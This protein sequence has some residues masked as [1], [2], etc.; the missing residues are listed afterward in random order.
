MQQHY[1]CL[2]QTLVSWSHYWGNVSHL[3]PSQ[4]HGLLYFNPSD[5]LVYQPILIIF[6]RIDGT[7]GCWFLFARKLVYTWFS[8][9]IFLFKFDSADRPSSLNY[10]VIYKILIPLS[11][12][13]L[14]IPQ[15]PW[16]LPPPITYATLPTFPMT[17]PWTFNNPLHPLLWPTWP[18]A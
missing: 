9:N 3:L 8:V 15:P 4:I 5:N 13:P 2:F 10:W 14:T 17:R 18:F 12:M 16:P 1:F 11:Y 7:D 6:L